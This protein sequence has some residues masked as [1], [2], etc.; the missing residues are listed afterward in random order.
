MRVLGALHIAFGIAGATVA[1]LYFAYHGAFLTKTDI[2]GYFI[3]GW[4]VLLLALAPPAVIAG[5][6]IRRFRPW[7]RSLTT[8]LS[9]F[10]LMSI[11]FGTALG[12]YSLMV[13][14]S[15]DVDPVFSPKFAHRSS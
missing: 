9:I 13:L 3:A 7:S 4:L 1:L 2:I 11:P 15:E 6:G 8:V 10:E 5:Y 14:L 12:I